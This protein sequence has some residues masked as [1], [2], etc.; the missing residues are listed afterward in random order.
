MHLF[1]SRLFSILK[2]SRLNIKLNKKINTK[3]L[4][5]IQEI[6]MNFPIKR[7]KWAVQYE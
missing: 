6:I 5:N 2:Q 3:K 4:C 1:F 7:T